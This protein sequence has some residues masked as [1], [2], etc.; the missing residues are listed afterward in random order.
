M[1]QRNAAYVAAGID[2]QQI[3]ITDDTGVARPTYSQ[4]DVQ[5]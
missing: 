1:C 4:R 5:G 3:H 2:N